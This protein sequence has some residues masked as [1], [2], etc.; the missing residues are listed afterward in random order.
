VL[1]SPASAARE[2]A[3]ALGFAAE[4][5]TPLGD[6]DYGRWRGLAAKDVARREP[7]AF[8]AWL[9][10]AAAAPHGGESLAALIERTG[11]W[12]HGSLAREGAT[13]AARRS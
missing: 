3:Q 8:A 5:E 11:T 2:T 9:G 10:D 4:V 12:L 6:C 13:L 1:T 7:E